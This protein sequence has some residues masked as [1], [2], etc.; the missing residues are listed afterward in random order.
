MKPDS[1]SLA[2]NVGI[3]DAVYIGIYNYKYRDSLSN[4]EAYNYKC[5]YDRGMTL[6]AEHHKL[7]Y[8]QTEET[9]G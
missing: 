6:Y 8:E 7:D 1:T 9:I 4:D 2:Y 5:G 3:T